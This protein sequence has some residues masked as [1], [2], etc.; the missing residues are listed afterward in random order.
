M[1]KR[2]LWVAAQIAFLVALAGFLAFALRDAWGDAAPRLR[3]ADLVD[4]AIAFVV[5]ACR[6]RRLGMGRAVLAQVLDV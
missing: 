2:R 1:P 3:D 4:L 6:E 5:C